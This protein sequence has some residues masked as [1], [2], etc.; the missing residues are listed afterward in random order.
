[1]RSRLRGAFEKFVDAERQSDRDIVELMREM[2]VDIAVDRNGFT[3]GA[4]PGIFAMRA[5]PIQVNYLGYPGTMGADFIDY[6]I[7]DETSFP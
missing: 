2:E 6:L 3:T 7:A 5:A 4:R 1:M